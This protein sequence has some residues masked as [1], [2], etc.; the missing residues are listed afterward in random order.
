MHSRAQFYRLSNRCFLGTP[1]SHRPA[2]GNRNFRAKYA[3]L[4]FSVFS[5]KSRRDGGVPG[6]PRSTLIIVRTQSGIRNPES[7]IMVDFTIPI[8]IV[9]LSMKG[10]RNAI[11]NAAMELFALEGLCRQLHPRNLQG[12][13]RNEAGSLLSFPQQRASVSGIDAGYFQPDT[14]KPAA[15]FEVSGES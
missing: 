13:G 15:A 9:I 7:R 5:I 4:V 11:L 1:A 3:R 10:A 12:G 14:K 6:K 2:A 8:G